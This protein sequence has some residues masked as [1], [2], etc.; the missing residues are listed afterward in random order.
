MKLC[1]QEGE[2]MLPEDF[3]FEIERSNPFFSDDGSATVPVTIPATDE[4][5]AKL[6]F[7][8]RMNR[9]RRYIKKKTAILSHKAFSKRCSLVI[10]SYANKSGITASLAFEESQMYAELQDKNIKEIFKN[11]TYSFSGATTPTAISQKL[12]QKYN[13]ALSSSFSDF[14]A[15]PVAVEE[16][17]DGSE[18]I[19]NATDPD[20]TR[21][22]NFVCAA[23]T[24]TIGS[25]SE[26][27]PE[28]YGVTPFITL[29]HFL[30]KTFSLCGYTIVRNDLASVPFDRLVILNN[31]ADTLCGQTQINYRDIVPSI[32]FGDLVEWL[33]NKFCAYVFIKNTDVSIIFFEKAVEETPDMDLTEYIQDEY[34]IDYPDP[35]SISRKQGSSID[36]AEPAF[37]DVNELRGTI[38]VDRH[39]IIGGANVEL[40]MYFLPATG[41]I[42]R[43][44]RTAADLAGSN[45]FPYHYDGQLPETSFDAADEFV[46]QVRVDETLFKYS[47]LHVPY[48]GDRLHNHTGIK[49]KV[50]AGEKE[51][52]KQDLMVCH[53]FVNGNIKL[54]G[55][56]QPFENA[57]NGPISYNAGPSNYQWVARQYPTLTPYGIYPYCWAKYNELLMNS[58]PTVEVEISLPGTMAFSMDLSK[59]KLFRGRKV[60]IV[61]YTVEMSNSVLKV[62]KMTLQQLPAYVDMVTDKSLGYIPEGYKLSWRLV[63]DP[64]PIEGKTYSEGPYTEADAPAYHPLFDGQIAKYR[65]IYDNSFPSPNFSYE[66]FVGYLQKL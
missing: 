40:G 44:T 45:C 14:V 18:F 49:A 15:F 55:N 6:G 54:C 32:T 22:T 8:D 43:R 38:G 4:M 64:A 31:C 63:Q 37:E 36:G 9:S 20:A 60:I 26:S 56:S 41:Q 24:I 62:A 57:N 17:E 5:R 12:F 47:E 2:L 28:G 29:K 21:P 16:Q 59:P 61:S 66:Y 48:V 33:K 25:N 39:D 42:Y 23:R 10:G 35:Q 34:S 52:S 46:P 51:D 65:F 27:V 3:A 50:E 53:C 11:E 58:F 19:L 30:E 7:P 1:I 13:D